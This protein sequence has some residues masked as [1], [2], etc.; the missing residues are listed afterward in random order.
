MPN[1]KSFMQLKPYYAGLK[2]V[3]K[4][5]SE[6]QINTEFKKPKFLRNNT[7]MKF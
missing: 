7:I 1:F 5:P 3:S 4:P 2:Y 6:E